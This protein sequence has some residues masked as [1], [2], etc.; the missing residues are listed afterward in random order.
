MTKRKIGILGGTFNPIHNGHIYLAREA[1]QTQNLDKV[2]FIP[3]NISYMKDQNE[4]LS[5]KMRYDMTVLATKDEPC[6]EVSDI[7]IERGG[8]SYTYETLLDLHK[9]YPNDALYY[10]IGAD[11]LFALETW[12]NPDIIFR[13]CNILVAYREGYSLKELTDKCMELQDK[14]H[15]N[16]TLFSTKDVPISSTMIREIL[17]NGD[18][19]QSILPECV[20][21]Y[22]I[23]HHIQF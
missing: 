3:S 23:S 18:D 19:P 6:F 7:E 9:L 21:Q 8:S 22:L 11:S 15:S 12:K 1:M 2:L 14:Y 5:S 16:I 17:H 4:I 13:E 10:I 20:F